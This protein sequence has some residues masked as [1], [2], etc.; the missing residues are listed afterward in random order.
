MLVDEYQDTNHAQYVLVR[1]LVGSP[2]CRPAATTRARCRPPSCA[3]SATPTSP[4]TRSAAPR[5]ATSRSSSGTSPTRPVILLEQNYRSTQNILAA[6]N[7]VVSRNTGPGAEEPLVRRGRRAADRRLRG[8]Q[9]ARRGRVRGRGGGPARRRGRGHPRRRWPCST[10]PTPSPGSSR[11]S[12]SGPGCP[13]RWSAGSGSTSGARSA[14]CSAYLRLI[15][16]PEDEVS[17][18]RVLNVPSAASATGPRRA[19]RRWPSVTGSPSRRRWPGPMTSPG[20]PPG[21]PGPSSRS[22]S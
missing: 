2:P 11:R 10:G 6:A 14:T 9:R 4:S 15:A 3:W 8:G 13:T 21:R 16:N 19:W 1:E 22:T 7:A 12:S 18:R 5:S 17:L 20:W